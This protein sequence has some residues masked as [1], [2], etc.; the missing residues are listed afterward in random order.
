MNP[1][2]SPLSAGDA[3]V[4]PGGAVWILGNPHSGRG[5]GEATARGIADALARAGHTPHLSL[6]HP[7]QAP[8][9][10]KAGDLRAL[11]VVGGDGTLRAAV[12]RF[13]EL[14][15][16][17][18]MLPPVL[19]VPM[20]TANLVGQYLGRPRTLFE[21]GLENVRSLASEGVRAGLRR[22]DDASL[23]AG[24][25][26]LG[27]RIH[28]AGNAVADGLEAS[29]TD[30]AAKIGKEVVQTLRDGIVR[31]LDVGLAD[32]KVFLLMAGIGFDA[33]VVH[34]LDRR[35]SGSIGL[36]SYVLPALSAITR[37]R[38]PSIEVRVDGARR[39]GP[40]P[41]V[42]MIANLPQ[43]G[44][45]FPIIP[46]AR[47]DDGLLDVVCLPCRSQAQLAK[48]FSLAT[49]GQHLT[50]PGPNKLRGRVIELRSD[51]EVPVQVDG[52]PAAHLPLRC[53]VGPRQIRF[54]SV[55]R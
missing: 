29:A 40:E 51:E 39:F 45:G 10:C 13:L 17:P 37:Y 30:R 26:R 25:E 21:L 44:T 50:V 19:P 47:G 22:M 33:H 34:A 41:A 2:S 18:A 11:I 32:G 12:E 6:V 48:I 43:Y 1:A 15:P 54:L 49:V 9:P 28:R 35:R 42:V 5:L 46:D 20:G 14:L 38:F 36:W 16:G 7:T 27:E 24:W 3:A 52:D 55:R 31:R 53:E 23:P 4:E 8:L